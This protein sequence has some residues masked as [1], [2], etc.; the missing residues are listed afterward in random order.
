VREA[1]APAGASARLGSSLVDPALARVG[2]P[3]RVLLLAVRNAA[4]SRLRV[5]LTLVTLAAS[6]V[7]F[8]SALNFR[9]S[10]VQTLD[11]LF[12]TRRADLSL[13]LA[14]DY[15]IDSV[16]RAARGTAGV[17]AAEAWVVVDAELA[18]TA[19]RTGLRVVGLPA[20]SQLMRFDLSRGEGLGQGARAVVVNTALFEQ[21]GRPA[22]GDDVHLRIDGAD[23]SLRLAGVAPSRRSAHRLSVTG[24]LRRAEREQPARRARECEP[25]CARR[26]EDGAGP[27]PRARER[28]RAGDDHEGREPFRLRRAH[29]HDLRLPGR[30]GVHPGR[31]GQPRPRHH[32][33]SERGRATPRDGRAARDRSTPGVSSSSWCSRA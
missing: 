10:M 31:G 33:R 19:P 9:L 23:A 13:R 32:D 12:E 28:S 26:R 11:R 15:P 6:G 4:R 29:G 20:A 30:G 7:F 21:L 8:M 16:E 17:S 24:L 2:G 27:E 5:A 1:L 22:L 18:G 14:E 25:G 3:S